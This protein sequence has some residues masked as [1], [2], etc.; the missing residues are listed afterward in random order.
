MVSLVGAHTLL[1]PKFLQS[2]RPMPLQEFALRIEDIRQDGRLPALPIV[3]RQAPMGV[4]L[5]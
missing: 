3:S 1:Y 4:P 2:L 5:E